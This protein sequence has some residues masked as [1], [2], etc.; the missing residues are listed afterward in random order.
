MRIDKKRATSEEVGATRYRPVIR[1]ILVALLLG[2]C[3]QGQPLWSDTGEDQPVPPRSQDA[4]PGQGATKPRREPVKKYQ[5]LFKQQKEQQISRETDQAVILNKLDR[6]IKEARRIYLSGKLDS[7]MAAYRK[8]IDDFESTLDEIPPAHPLLK[9]MEERFSVFEE[10][11]TKVLG[12][13]QSAPSGDATDQ[14]FQ[15]LERRRVCRRNLA[16]KKAGP[17]DFFDVPKKLLNEE[18]QLQTKLLELKS[19][20]PSPTS[21]Q[22]LEAT[23]NSLSDLRKSL[24][25]SSQR[26]TLFRKGSRLGVQKVSRDLLHKNEMI[27]DFSLLADRMVVGVITSET[28]AYYQIPINRADVDREVLNLQE[29]LREFTQEG[30]STFMG[31]AWKEPARRIYRFLLGRLP[32]L[33]ENRTTIFVIPDRSLWYLPFSVMLDADDRPFGRDRLI[34][35]IP[36]VDML[37]FLRAQKSEQ[38]GFTSDLLLL[39]SIPW[40]AAEEIRDSA[41]GTPV[42]EKI[43]QK[44]SNEEKVERL[45]LNNPVYP[46]PSEVVVNIQKT[47]KKSHLWIGPT[48]TFDRLASSKELSQRIAIVAVP[49]AVNDKL[50]AENPPTFFFS[51]DKNGQRAFDARML[52]STPLA[53][54][55]MI[56]PVAWFEVKDTDNISGEGPLLL[57][58]AVFYSGSRMCM[59]NYSD[60]DWGADEHFLMLT[61]KRVSEKVPPGKALGEYK[62]DITSEL[63]ASFAGKPPG[64]VGWIL[65]GDPN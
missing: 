45:I 50:D 15:L 48:A 59:V 19:E 25:K 3:F 34:A 38:S 21:R 12:P 2:F 26:Y 28:A 60:P 35:S 24:D 9:Q 30:R 55:L 65:M 49:L 17:V 22:A 14:V 10:F 18:R 33:P 58:S 41:A 57:S 36:S 31:H 32:P 27:L 11:I 62:R 37:N 8:V 5:W 13:L 7:A 16:L 53:C 46:R 43:A 54:Q 29:M 40:I 47:F 64:W 56:L 4:S 52:F 61:L 23:Q 63:S 6:E 42:R 20:V 1:S 51:P 44:K 39:E